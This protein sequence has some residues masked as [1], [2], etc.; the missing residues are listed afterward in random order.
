MMKVSSNSQISSHDR[1]AILRFARYGVVLLTLTFVAVI[2][3]AE[4][5]ATTQPA[6][7][8]PATTQPATTQP[9][10]T[11]SEVEDALRKARMA[12]LQS[13]NKEAAEPAEDHA[14]D[15]IK[16][17]LQ[18]PR[19]VPPP[20][21][22][23]PGLAK[24]VS[25]AEQPAKA[26]TVTPE[27]KEA[28]ATPNGDIT[29]PQPVH[30]QF[31]T[32]T[33][34]M[35]APDP[36]A[37]TYRF[38]YDNTPWADVLADFSRMSGLPFLNQ[39]DP[40]ITEALTFR[41]PREM[42]YREALS[43]INE[44]LV[45]RPLNKYLIK[46]QENYLLIK[47][48][49]DWMREIAPSE[50]FDSFEEM[51]AAN[52]DAYDIVLVNLEVP[53]G[54]SPFE[55][56]EKYRHMFSDTYGTQV[57]GDRLEMTGL[58]QEHR[59]FREVINRLTS[60]TPGPPPSDPR[61]TLTIQFKIARAADVQTMLRQL[62]PGAAPAAQARGP[63]ID[64]VAETAR[65]VDIFADVKSNSLIIKAQPRLLSEIAEWAAKLDT[66]SA[67]S[68]PV[69]RVVRLE[70]ADPNTLSAALKPIFMKEQ[71][72]LTKP[73]GPYV[74][75]DQRADMERDIFPDPASNSVI[76]IGGE[77]GVRSAEQLVREWDKPGENT[78][79]EII[80]LKH[81]D[82]TELAGILSQIFPAAAKPGQSADRITP[83]TS[84]S[85]LVS[86][87]KRTYDKLLPLLEKLDVPAEAE[88]KEHLVQPKAATPSAL[89]AI[90]QSA[91]SGVTPARPAPGAKRPGQPPA[92][93]AAAPVGGPG[94]RFIPDDATGYLIVYCIDSDW[95]RIEPLILTLDER[96]AFFEPRL[97]TYT[98]EHASAGDVVNMLQQMF[99]P[100]PPGTGQPA[101]QQRSFFADLYNNTVQVFASEEFV[102]KITPFIRQLDIETTGEL[103]VIKLEHSD[104]ETIAPILAQSVGGTAVS[105]AP[106]AARVA[107]AGKAAQAQQQPMTVAPTGGSVRIVSEP[108]TNSLLV[109]APSKE[110]QQI[111]D[112]VTKIEHEAAVQKDRVEPTRV[113]LSAQHRTAEE[114]VE[115]MRYLAAAP[116]QIPGGPRAAA[117][118]DV[119]D[120]AAEGLK[121]VASGQQVVMDG[122]RDQVAKAVLL[123]EQIDVP[124]EQMIFRKYAVQDAEENEKKLRAMLAQ[125]TPP[126]VTATTGQSRGAAPP[127]AAPKIATPESIL[128]YADTYE[129]TLLV[130]ARLESELTE[131]ERI[132]EL[133][134]R[135]ASTIT[136]G[137]DPDD[138]DLGFFLVKLEHKKAF[139]IAFDVEDILNP[140]R[141]SNGIRLDEG[142]TERLLMVRN[143][144]PGQ[145]ARVEEVV[146]VF[147]VPKRGMVRRN[148]RTLDSE[149]LPPD[150]LVK[151]LQQQYEK[152]I[153]L[154]PLGDAMGRVKVIDIH[155]GEEE[156]ALP[157]RKS[158]A[159]GNAN[160]C[161]L[162]LSL[163]ETLS[164]FSLGQSVQ[165]NQ[166]MEL[167]E[168]AVCPICQQSPCMLPAELLRSI[169][170]VAMSAVMHD[171]VTDTDA[172][173][174]GERVFSTQ[175]PEARE[176]PAEAATQEKEPESV[177]II[178]DPDTGKIILRGPEDELEILTDLIDEITSGDQPTVFRVFPLKYSDVNV[179]SQLLEQIFNQGQA[180]AAGGRRGRQQQLQPQMLPV[181]QVPQQGQPGQPGQQAKPG[182]P[183]AQQ[184]MQ[185]M[186]AMQQQGPARIKVVPDP[187]TK[188]LFVAALL[189]DVPLIVDV[190]RKI[191]A[192]VPPGASDI[193]M[194]RLT[195]LD[196]TQVVENLKEVLGLD[197]SAQ[198]RM[199][200]QRGGRQQGMQQP[201]GQPDQ[202]QILQL[203]GQQ[204]QGVVVSSTD[205]INLTADP[206]T[207]TIIARA[208]ADTLELIEAL[209]EEL[210]SEENTTKSEMRRVA[211]VHARAS[212]VATIVKDVANELV[213]G[214]GAVGGGGPRGGRGGRGGGVGGRVAVNADTRTNSVI[215]AGQSKDVTRVAEIVR[216]MDIP[217]D[218]GTIRQFPVKGDAAALATLLKSLFVSGNQTDIIITGDNSTGTV[219]VKAPPTQMGEIAEQ[220]R[221]MDEKVAGAKE[222]KTITMLVADPEQ[223]AP[224]LN[225]IFTATRGTAGAKQNITITGNKNNS[226]LYVMGAD[227]E[228]FNMIK[229]VAKGMDTA[230]TGTQVKRFPM[231]HASAVEINSQLTDMLVK[232][233]QTG[234]LEGVKLDFVG[235]V[236][237]PRTNSL[238]VTG[239]PLTFGLIGSILNEIDVAPPES[240][241]RETRSYQ[242]P[243]SADPNQ[244]MSNIQAM[245]A[246]TAAQKTGLEAPSVTVNAA[247]NMVLVTANIQQHEDIK[248]KIID[249]IVTALGS[250]FEDHR[251][252]LKFIKAE[253]ARA[254]LEDFL[255]K[256]RTSRGNKPHD[257]F[258]LTADQNSNLLLVNCTAAT[259][260]VIEKQLA[261]IDVPTGVR[262]TRFVQLQHAK[263]DEV[264]RAMNESFRGK[265]VA[266]TKG[267]WPVTVVA[268]TGSNTLVITAM[269]DLWQEVEAMAKAL[270]TEDASGRAQHVIEVAN[271]NP[272]DVANA[273]QQIFNA[274]K[275]ARRQTTS[276]QVQAIPNS[277]KLLVLANE[278]EIVLIREL[279]KKIDVE[280]G[281][282]VH[283]VVMP[284]L[285][286]A[287]SVSEAIRQL[288]GAQGP[289]GSGVKAEYHEP[290]NTLLVYATAAEFNRIKAQIIDKIS[291]QPTVGAMQ[292]YQIP[293]KFAVADEVAKTLQSFFDK[294]AGV[295]GSGQSNLPPWMRGPEPAAKQLENQVS[296]VAEPTSNTLLVYCTETTKQLMDEII[297]Q[298]DAD[299]SGKS[300]M[301]MV[302]LKYVDA[303]EVISILTEYLRVSK[304]SPEEESR[305]FVPWWADREEKSE[306]KTVLAGDMRLK[307]VD[308]LNA[309]IVVGR[310]EG[311]ADAVAKIKELDVEQPDGADAPQR[312]VLAHANATEL[313][314]TLNKVFNDPNIAKSKGASYRPPIIVPEEATKSIIVRAKSSDFNMIRKMAENLDSQMEGDTGAG[315]RVLAVPVGRDL[316]EMARNI[317]QR[318]NDAERN[319]QQL[320]R[321]YKPSLVSIGADVRSSALIVAGSRGKY[322]EVKSIVEELVAMGPAGG[323]R[324]A[325]IQ[326][327]TLSSQEAKQIIDQ[328]QQSG[329]GRSGGPRGDAEWTR[330][331]RWRT[332]QRAASHTV[333]C[334]GTL[335]M[336]LMQVALTGAVAQSSSAEPTTQPSGP[337]I[338]TI[339]PRETTTQPSGSRSEK[340]KSETPGRGDGS[341]TL[342]SDDLLRAGIEA[343]QIDPTRMTDAAKAAL[344][345]RL[346]GGPISTAEAGPD[347][348]VIEAS[349]EDMEVIISVLE[350]LDTALPGKVIEYVTLKNAS[351][352]DLAKT[353]ADVFATIEKKGQRQPRPEDKVDVIADPRTNGLYIAATR[354]KMEQV[355][356]LVRKND[357]AAADVLQQVRTFVFQN[358][359][360]S[361][362]GE[363]LKKM[364]TA[365]LQQKGLDPKLIQVEIDPQTNSVF[366]T[367]GETD[368]DFVEKIIAGLDAELPPGKDDRQ[369][370][371]EADVMIIPLRIAQAD[372]LG[373]LLN[374]LLKKAATGDTP[375]KD[376]I[377]R[378]RLLDD[379]GE[380]LA[381]V[382]LDRPVIVFGDK[383]SNSLLI[384]S[385]RENCLI[386]KQVVAAFDKEPARAEVQYKVFTL[387]NADASEVAEQVSKL[388][389]EGENLTS[390][391][392]KSEK[393]GVPD[394]EAG[395]LV[396]KAVVTSD[397]RT[398]QLVI[399][400][401]PEAIEVL[402]ELVTS[403]D[404]KGLDVMPFTLVRLE[405]ASVSALETA[406]SEMMK[407]RA[408]ALPR[409][410]G[411]NAGKSETVIIK[412]DPRSKSLIIAAKA[413]RL[414]ELRGLIKQLDVPSTALVEDIR[415]I[416]L[417]N[418]SA[419]DLAE[420]LKNLWEQRAQQQ[421]TGGTA[422]KLETPAIVADERSN[423]LIV[424]A[425]QGDFDAIKGVVEKIEA[426]ELNP[427]A[428]IYVVRLKF[429]SAK[430]LQA[431]FKALFEKRA[432]MRT[433][434]GKTR[435]EDEVAIEV[436]ETMNAILF[437]GSRE[438][439]DVLMQKLVELDQELGV[440]GVIEFFVCENVG[441][442]RVK[443]TIE[444]LFKDSGLYK[445]G[446]SGESEAAKRR[447]KVTVSIDDRSNMLLVS[448]SPENME[449]IR[450]IYRRMNSV[451]TPW[452]V[453]ITKM[454]VIEHGDSVKIAAQ[455]A[456][457]FKKLDEL[458]ETGGDSGKKSGFGITVF[459]D[460]RSN[461]IIVGGTK[462][463]IDSAV[464]LIGRLDV[465]PGTPGQVM[466]VY[467]LREAPAARIGEMIKN[468]FEERNKPRQ[469]GEGTGV[470]IPNITVT[471][472][473]DGGRNALLINASREDHLLIADLVRRLDRPS[474]IL[475][476]ARVIP[477]ERAPAERVK[478]IL[479]ELYQSG[480]GGEGRSGGKVIGVVEDKRT[481]AVVVTAP[482]GELENI[483]SLVER[484]DKTEVK[485]QAEVGVFLC[486]NED[487]EKMAEVLNEIMTGRGKEGGSSTTD[488]ATQRQLSS[489]LISFADKDPF[490]REL[491]LK[492]IRENVQITFNRRTNSII[493]VAPPSS[494]RLIEQLVRKL[495]SIQKRSVM[496]KVFMLRHADAVKMIEMLE[497]MFAQDE[498]SEAQAEFQ[499]DR[500]IQVEGGGTSTSGVPQAASQEGPS[501][502][503]TFG[504]PKTTFTADE[505]TNSLIAAG[506]PEDIDV[507][508][509]IIDQLDSRP[510]Q[511]RDYFVY[512]LVN[513]TAD[514]MQEAL[515]AYFQAEVQRL[516]ALGDVISPQRRMEQ[517]VSIISHPESNQL[518]ISSSP[519]YKNQVVSIIE[520]LD[521]APAQ[522]MIQVM[523]AEVTLDDRFEMGLEFA[524][525]ELRFSET[526]VADANGI[527]QSSHFDV[528]GGTD[529]GAAGSGLGGFS[530]TITGEDFNFLV[531]ALQSDSRLEVIQRPM[532]MCQDN[533]QATIQ[534]GQSV[535]TPSGSQAFAGQ[536]S[537]QVQYQDVGVILNVEPHIN[538]DG[539]VYMLVEPEISSVSDST[540]QIAP[541]AFAP[542]F[543]RRQ[544]STNV[545][546]KDGETVVIGGL[547]TTTETESESKVPLLGDI[548][549]LGVL[550][551]TTVRT[552]NRT[553]LLIALT[554]RIVRTVEDARRISIAKRDESGIITDNM[555]QSPLFE[556]LQV[557]P[558]SEEAIDTLEF[559][560]ED[561]RVLPVMPEV[562]DSTVPVEPAGTP[563]QPGKE[564]KP[565]YGPEPPKYGPLVPSG[566]EIVARRTAEPIGA[567]R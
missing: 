511:D 359:R 419:G 522:V 243:V 381:T 167:L 312:I 531:R 69:M 161:V 273:L 418:T 127:P 521:M 306:D 362:A 70:Y 101:P 31:T 118:K 330:D 58:V 126:T 128:I 364:V 122:P 304:R 338:G 88:E 376:F 530:F 456:D 394:G 355:L 198:Q 193:R 537:T 423:S 296:I 392:G 476:M 26:E 513:Q 242:L 528:V 66:G 436:D 89:A 16:K 44:L 335:P 29:A 235:A 291:E 314:D 212:D 41:S 1:A 216:E 408:E 73:D 270:D 342:T 72:A 266:N 39:P 555:K 202:Q 307:A 92:Q 318:I 361:E 505:R 500:E 229:D 480:E 363:V 258:A 546:V 429:N 225:E 405:Y 557:K 305:R 526:A 554:P 19:P 428:N 199:Q 21:V 499:R 252:P 185:M 346:S 267:H 471:V 230:P 109:T 411:P 2:A 224:R 62:Y 132:L 151:L 284:E 534:I 208:P 484:L 477:L 560:P 123:F 188:S 336:L 414:E 496:V 283:T 63:G 30:S 173:K 535:P 18:T 240:I 231:K 210:D 287:K 275:T 244:V 474:T 137:P 422:F 11:P 365:Y 294:K 400:G 439:Y 317:E 551:R 111:R 293:L 55:I 421:D 33:F 349:E 265:T 509:D 171:A 78:I 398:N 469:G 379:R 552:K 416:T 263:A 545:A 34:T 156:P 27:A 251:I 142:P 155:E 383:E 356:E 518:V 389:T 453:A 256:W 280:G 233:K 437:A 209:I 311:V 410:T 562:I 462:D 82:A 523:I 177:S 454:V 326:L 51:E 463:G 286:P 121:I 566:E 249:P 67:L 443:D 297:V 96:A 68:L 481:N 517:E 99:P 84:T 540:I 42:T 370:I 130:G 390:R 442:H 76:L 180:V 279:V 201:Q 461:R 277:T 407:E 424:A 508:A 399:V 292:I 452:D 5:T 549:G 385:S 15:N 482:P 564:E 556:G 262:E 303:A 357:E 254:T 281:R 470:Q 441:A 345:R 553:E 186:Q 412:G 447:E 525:Q 417:R 539:F 377:R 98:L 47:R 323:T 510:I 544:A 565:R 100:Q 427:M 371:G 387:T 37:R 426:L 475:D 253:D 174:K 221:Q 49:P 190:L 36:E 157:L 162:P 184:Q 352:K 138:V 10:T 520:Q 150:M 131:V 404:V 403:L 248:T 366:I 354:D 490:G 501:R 219:L 375:M 56:I 351:A 435:P 176:E 236:P 105:P 409:G 472:E 516:D 444:E 133:I 136:G 260:E 302:Q 194:F 344:G 52:P 168:P 542:I 386:M 300:V 433:V 79:D 143:C 205:N 144:K 247:S 415:T 239:G 71:Q 206:Q 211:L 360:V 32:L 388:L 166:P 200:Q 116:K 3:R 24:P 183:Q 158:R 559:A 178:Y 80:E 459:A 35:A 313:A 107:T 86:V 6:T 95:E 23:K 59:R 175:T 368:L 543:N 215:L 382:N 112:L 457:Y 255:N 93:P 278:D 113:I 322:E 43:Q 341:P 495:D 172:P 396:Y 90:L 272:Q 468:V 17:R 343:G 163:I 197:A 506:W 328:L 288:Y 478:E 246:T 430:N 145:R 485:G 170:S 402:S 114:L 308:S 449:L 159:T 467:T 434:D 220:L 515:D 413:N 507:V 276:A 169:D 450:E 81:A 465:P 391:P 438:N 125:S 65:K 299:P 289:G 514:S 238:V 329:K 406:L 179:A 129:N 397:A 541:G 40:P 45:A 290:T 271:S 203:Q 103:T 191:D 536:T 527:L 333:A 207:N 369:P 374:E 140:D 13:V 310:P 223:I 486:D 538:P 54:W 149:K 222:L 134:F 227:P 53:K 339:R 491:F 189:S 232:A 372:S 494:L 4:E 237:D 547:I 512:T 532:I 250:P 378:F 498:G 60:M 483:V 460:E 259:R 97:V 425:S 25:P 445:P 102:T 473:T 332:P 196:A 57:N 529:L 110:L 340:T 440:P 28:P 124:R 488:E 504:R 458:R 228:T 46:R 373:T 282:E 350:M 561:S 432:Q 64:Q 192:P 358:R 315:V 106:Q 285:V 217:S 401:R 524:L 548:P 492:T 214:G 563:K 431:A 519:R 269:S 75:P 119:A 213:G 241:V 384:A 479:E 464:E 455:V 558:P 152:P 533:Q 7:T 448:A 466:E 117:S 87:S 502:R 115:T 503:G 154:I 182:T 85:L 327:K 331:R 104:A 487:A 160:P 321:D 446:A 48:L 8:Q 257:A 301:E 497:K 493:A 316:E 50:M 83:R 22:A 108:I 395:S 12:A 148:I 135:E 268:D 550:F 226:T 74:S 245:F 38:D 319:R 181:P 261:D 348:I 14:D 320:Q 165:A 367:A 298:I 234:G 337:V 451:T 164:A 489:M 146:K 309:I 295:R 380:P 139:D 20:P 353:L 91:M 204:G 218:G 567:G 264:A 147:D 324:R 9:A 347:N 274:E 77:S 141:K 334:A 195:N 61:P 420:K 120:A 153:N 325:V 393:S 187:R 94:P